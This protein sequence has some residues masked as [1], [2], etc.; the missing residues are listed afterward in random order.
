MKAV[1]QKGYG[2]LGN[3]S[4]RDIAVPE[5]GRGE[6]AVRVEACG[7]NASDWE[8][9]TGR[10]GYARLAGAFRPRPR[11]LGSDVVG[12]VEAVGEGVALQVGQRVVADT[13]GSFGGFAS[14][15]VAKA[16]RF[17]PVAADMDPTVV[18]CL[19]QSGTIVLDAFSDR[20]R[21]G[22]RV[23]VNGAGGGSGPMAIQYAKSLGAH[24]TG[25]DNVGKLSVMAAAG[26]DEVRDYE[27]W[28]FA[29]S[30][31]TWDVILD[32]YGT[33]RPRELV[34]ALADG[35]R[36]MMVGGP[37]LVLIH[38]ALAGLRKR[39]DGKS[40]GVLAVNQGP[41]RL[42][43]LMGLA[44]DGVISPVIGERVQI[45]GAMQALA[46]MGAGATPGKLVVVA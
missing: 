8:F 15:C 30:G 7:A 9:V 12:V 26:A 34:P 11:V 21:A 2:G 36:Y 10:P 3:L 1:V 16:D 32:M 29:T 38:V 25:V 22:M 40:I 44:R 4:L 24:V 31:E 19:P 46:R 17:V 23:L 41:D 43:E 5:A 39:R 13:F 42:A 14:I 18:A 33:R 45:E 20:V 6:V 27:A 28:D 35:G 37:M